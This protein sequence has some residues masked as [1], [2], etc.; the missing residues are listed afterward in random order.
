MLDESK[1]FGVMI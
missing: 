1:K